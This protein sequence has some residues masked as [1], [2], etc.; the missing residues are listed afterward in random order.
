MAGLQSESCC[1]LSQA[2]HFTCFGHEY[3]KLLARGPIACTYMKYLSLVCS[4]HLAQRSS[5]IQSDIIP[6]RAVQVSVLP[7]CTPVGAI[8]EAATLGKAVYL[9]IN[10]VLQTALTIFT[11][12]YISLAALL[13]LFFI[14]FSLARSG[15]VGA[16]PPHMVPPKADTFWTSLAVR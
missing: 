11:D 1:K 5:S 14:C 9:F 10:A 6:S 7:Q 15:G 12:S 13:L 8:L 2:A 4:T 3:T 16:I